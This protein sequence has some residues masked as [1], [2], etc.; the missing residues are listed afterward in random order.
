MNNGKILFLLC[1]RYKLVPP[2]FGGGVAGG[3]TSAFFGRASLN[4]KEAKEENDE[5]WPLIG[6]PL[7]RRE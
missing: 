5:Q 6:A 2:F 1:Y 3:L 4:K 7:G